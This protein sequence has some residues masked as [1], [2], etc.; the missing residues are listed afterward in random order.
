MIM[1]RHGTVFLSSIVATGCALCSPG[2]DGERPSAPV[3]PATAAHAPTAPVPTAS[4]STAAAALA[5]GPDNTSIRFVGAS[6]VNRQP[7]TFSRF[8]GRLEFATN[9]PCDSRLVIEIAMDSVATNIPL[10]TK[11]L[12]R[13]DFFDVEH[14]PKATFVS[15]RVEASRAAGAT[16]VLTGSLTIHGVTRTLSIP[17]RFAV[18]DDLVALDA[19]LEVRQSEFGMEKAARKSD[20]IVPITLSSRLVRSLR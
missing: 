11:H 18:S 8:S 19:T 12:K 15:T 14:F 9:D 1:F 5:I 10:L 7:G 20:D 4:D 2:R 17:A 16:H 6:L 13:A 3:K